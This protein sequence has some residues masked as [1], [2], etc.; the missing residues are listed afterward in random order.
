M[1][2]LPLKANACICLIVLAGFYRLAAQDTIAPTHGKNN[3][4]LKALIAPAALI[5]S[6]L[7]AIPYKYDVRD[8]RNEKYPDFHTHADNYLQFVP[9]IGVYGLNAAGIHGKNDLVN[10][11]AL[12]IKSELLMTALVSSLKYTTHVLRP[13]SSNYYSFP[14]GHTA[15]AF[16]A[17]TFLQKEYGHLS[18]WYTIGGY[19]VATTV[20][21]LRILNNK[22]WISDVL[23]GAGIGI[24]STNLVYLTH[25]YRWGKNKKSEATL[26]PTYGKGPGFY[27]CLRIK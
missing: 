7:L 18:I 9:I 25:R 10:R 24:L 6:G 23:V 20:G 27:F 15:Q 14:S 4:T 22:H 16:A 2:T 12:L 1:W 26:I 8:Q 3:K 13:D 21:A 17:A 5:T 11:T 19:G